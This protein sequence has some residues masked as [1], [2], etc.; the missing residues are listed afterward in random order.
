MPVFYQTPWWFKIGQ[1]AY[2]DWKTHSTRRFT[3]PLRLNRFPQYRA[4]SFARK[5]KGRSRIWCGPRMDTAGSKRSTK[6]GVGDHYQY[7]GCRGRAG[8]NRYRASRC[9]EPSTGQ[10]AGWPANSIK[11]SRLLRFDTLT[12]RWWAQFLFLRRSDMLPVCWQC[13]STGSRYK[14]FKQMKRSPY[15]RSNRV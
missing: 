6:S 3:W 12:S 11:Q 14:L 8:H 1:Y 9:E 2:M 7:L 10:L 5:S 4:Y 15:T 13:E